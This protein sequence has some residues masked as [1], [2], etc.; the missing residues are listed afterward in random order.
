M[1]L[2]ALSEKLVEMN[3]TILTMAYRSLEPRTAIE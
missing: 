1:R 2:V 3:W